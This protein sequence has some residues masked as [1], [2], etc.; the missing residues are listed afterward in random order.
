[1]KKQ[2]DEE[3]EHAENFMKYQNVRGGRLV[4]DDVK[5]PEKNEWGSALEAFEKA[6]ELERFNN[7]S[8]LKLHA[9]TTEANDPA[10]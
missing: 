6:L 7:E 4:L 2:S 3:R 9:M 10:V 5:K 8:L 1:M